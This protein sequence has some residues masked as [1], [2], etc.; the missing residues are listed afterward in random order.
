MSD[1]DRIHQGLAAT[2]DGLADVVSRCAAADREKLAPDGYGEFAST[3][4]A[5]ALE[6]AQRLLGKQTFTIGFAGAFSA[7]KSTIV[8][9]LM[10]EPDMLPTFAGEC[11]MSITVVQPPS[12]G[13]P[14]RVEAHY[15]TR[16]DA[17]RYVLTNS[18][19]QELL[20]PDLPGEGP[21]TSDQIAAAIKGG[22][23]R[24]PKSTNHAGKEREL[25]EFIGVLTEMAD[26]L[27]RVHVDT[28]AN[29]AMYLT[30]GVGDRG[31]GHLLCIQEVH[32]FKNCR[33]LKEMGVEIVDLPGTDSVNERQ[34]QLTYEYLS[35]ADAVMIMLEPRG[36]A[37]S[38][39]QIFE[40]MQ[41]HYHD[42]RNKLFFVLNQA[43]KWSTD[44]LKP[45]SLER[46]LRGQVIQK[47]ADFGLDPSRLYL[48]SALRQDLGNRQRD[49]KADDGQI[50]TLQNLIADSQKKL[51]ALDKGLD[52]T[53]TG[54]IRPM[55]EDG[56]VPHLRSRLSAYLQREIRLER[57]REVNRDVK[58]VHDGA[59]KVLSGHN[60]KIT[61]LKANTKPY[62]RQVLDF[63]E[64]VRD[65]VVGEVQK[66]QG[67]LENGTRTLV[68]R[69]KEQVAGMIAGLKHYKMDPIIAKVGIPNPAQVKVEALAQW[70]PLL[71]QKFRELI[72]AQVAAPLV[73]RL[74]K[75]LRGSAL[76]QVLSHF[77]KPA[78]T[79]W[80]E[81][82]DRTVAEFGGVV[83]QVTRLRAGECTKEL[84]KSDMRP[85]GFEPQ[86]NAQVE[87][88]FKE[89]CVQ[90]FDQR[91]Q[92]Y[93]ETLA[94]VLPGYYQ[95]LCENLGR[96]VT[97]FLDEVSDKVRDLRQVS[98]PAALLGGGDDP[99]ARRNLKLLELSEAYEAVTG[100]YQEASAALASAK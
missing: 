57:L 2:R 5:Q 75:T 14:E 94:T 18:R 39:R 79:Q 28:L 95:D 74:A 83:G 99:E 32:L 58:S 37:E 35:K 86:W 81:Q 82:F 50:S 29:A 70:R 20:K 43:D 84:L 7:G 13:T 46:L 87:S 27:G 33:G 23:E 78:G 64:Q 36:I 53:L 92:A 3:M 88:A 49:G 61:K 34:K 11:T 85:A 6:R 1:L 91:F 8:N 72:E 90:L 24:A 89:S 21:F 47:I 40:Q 63:F 69:A 41:K 44:D 10:G 38:G 71:A 31:L 52:G 80:A 65:K 48:T 12:D 62:H 54:L 68:G 16:E 59:G 55:L 9:A 98:I 17:L 77:D 25:G 67:G 4:P 45:A 51:S 96:W 30:T 56:G 26:R 93:S 19:Y 60:A 100:S 15:F 42:V 22:I 76:P 97:E 73:D 66:L